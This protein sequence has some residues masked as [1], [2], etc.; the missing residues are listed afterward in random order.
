MTTLSLF[1]ALKRESFQERRVWSFQALRGR[2]EEPRSAPSVIIT[3]LS[4][5]LRIH[6]YNLTF[7]ASLRNTGKGCHTITS[8][9]PHQFF[10][11]SHRITW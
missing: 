8:Q 10:L 4:F 7:L 11:P 6:A 2:G 5:S 3:Q 1:T 9:A